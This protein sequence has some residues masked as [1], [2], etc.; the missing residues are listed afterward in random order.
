MIPETVGK[1]SERYASIIIPEDFTNSVN[2]RYLLGS[3]IPDSILNNSFID[4]VIDKSS[5]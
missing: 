4:I 3:T 1:N 2:K 5:K